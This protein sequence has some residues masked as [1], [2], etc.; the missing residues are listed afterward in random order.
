[1][2]APAVETTP[3]VCKEFGRVHL[4]AVEGSG[5]GR[6]GLMVHFEA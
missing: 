5:D 3:P 6:P 2:L 4:A 1:M